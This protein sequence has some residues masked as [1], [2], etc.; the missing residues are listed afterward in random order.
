MVQLGE[1]VH[2]GYFSQ[3]VDWLDSEASLQDQITTQDK[4]RE[5]A[6]FENARALGLSVDDLNRHIKVLSRGQRAKAAILELLMNDYQL[7]VLDEPTNHLD[8]ATRELFEDAL[9]RYRGA[10]LFA[11]HDI[12]F[13]N[14]LSVSRVIEL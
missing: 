6:L 7:L 13:S 2:L 14:S 1:G 11:S 4:D 5:T 8:I 10:I 9:S 12:S 3:D